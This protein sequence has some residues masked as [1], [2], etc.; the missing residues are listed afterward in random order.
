M[1]SE[2]IPAS[3]V[4]ILSKGMNAWVIDRANQYIESGTKQA[5]REAR[6]IR[7]MDTLNAQGFVYVYEIEGTIR[8]RLTEKGKEFF[9]D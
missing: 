3:T 1:T 9:H 5:Q 4:E 8:Y 7:A 6:F 2:D